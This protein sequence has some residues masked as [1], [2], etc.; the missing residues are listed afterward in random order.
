MI[1]ADSLRLTVIGAVMALLVPALATAVT[2]GE[3]Q[4]IQPAHNYVG[5][6]ESLQRGAKYFVNYCLG[7]HS[8]KYV[9]Y[10]RLA[11]DLGLSEEQL[12]E[13]LMF[14]GERPYDAMTNAMPAEDAERWFG[15]APPDLSLTARSEGV[16]YIYSY[17][18]SFYLDDERPTGVNNRV[19]EASAM[20]HVLWE[21]QGWQEAIFHEE[22]AADGGV[23]REF[24]RFEP[25][26]Q[27]VLSAEEY[28]RFVR[29][30]A[31]F[32]DYVSE[33]VQLERRNLGVLVILFL[34]VFLLF[35]WM[36]KKEYWKRVQ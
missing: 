23:N 36:L 20:P 8:A 12:I 27:G 18:K 30:I 14:T 24:V 15:V 22:Q 6:V 17:L 2:E 21:L 19:L 3:S 10:N 28:D 7:C 25:V 35:A 31:N 11:E 1:N 29:D 16:D 32:L 26:T 13:N 5:N 4:A 34:L 9:R 33:P